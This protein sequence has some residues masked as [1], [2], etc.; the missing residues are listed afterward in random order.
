M[1]KIE[2]PEFESKSDR[3]KFLKKNKSSLIAQKKAIIKHTDAMVLYPSAIQGKSTTTIKENNPVANPGD[4]LKV[5][6]VINTTN[7]LDS[8]MDVHLPGIWDKS[9]NENKSIMFLQEHRMAFDKIIADGG[10]L[11]ALTENFVWSALGQKFPGVT[12]AL[13]FEANI[14]KS[15]NEF[16]LD[17]YANGFVKQHSVGMRYI[18]LGL[19]LNDS[20]SSNASEFEAWEKYFNEIV[21]PEVA[22][23]KGFFWFVK[24]AKA[25]EGSAV[26][27]GSNWVT[28]TLDNNQKEEPIIVT[29]TIEPSKDTQDK[30][31]FDGW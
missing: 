27:L 29:P 3:I 20:S 9:L 18:Q 10:D 7:L 22:D 30:G 8:H 11:T 12:E 4:E 21:N 1:N 23:E 5:K 14:R 26:P 6:V 24:E 25:I 2:L 19:A 15:R 31:F 13:V 28:P 16:M 17:Q